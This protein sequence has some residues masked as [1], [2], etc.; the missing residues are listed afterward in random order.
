MHGVWCGVVCAMFVVNSMCGVC[1]V[2]FVVC[3][4]HVLCL[5]SVECL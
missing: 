3:V 1:G 5:W 2:V 4:M